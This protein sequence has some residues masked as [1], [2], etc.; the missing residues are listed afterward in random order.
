M[1]TRMADGRNPTKTRLEAATSKRNVALARVQQQEEWR[2][3]MQKEGPR[4]DRRIAEITKRARDIGEALRKGE[5]KRKA[6]ED[7]AD[8]LSGMLKELKTF[9]EVPVKDK[10][11]E[12][13]K[14]TV[15]FGSMLPVLIAAAAWWKLA[16]KAK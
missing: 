14:N 11:P 8:I 5:D 2:R 6:I 7:F 10:L 1:T 12:M 9:S 15:A 13:P 16:R 3:K 4:M